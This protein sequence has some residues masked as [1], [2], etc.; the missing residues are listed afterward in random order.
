VLLA[1]PVTINV[2]ELLLVRDSRDP[3]TIIPD[4]PRIRVELYTIQSGDS[5][6]AIAER[7]GLQPETIA[8]SNDRSLIWKL[9]PG[10]VLNIMPV[11][12]VYHQAVGNTTVRDLAIQYGVSDPAVILQSEY[13]NL[14]AFD[15]D[16]VLPSGLWVV[17]PGGRAEAINFAPV[18]ETVSGGGESGGGL[19]SYDPSSPGTC[20]ALAAGIA[21]GWVSP[22]ASYTFMRGFTSFHTG[23][24]L[25]AGVGTPVYA[26][27]SGRVIFAGRSNYGYGIAVVISHGPFSTL[28]GHLNSENVSCGQLVG[29]GQLIGAVGL[30]GNTSGPHLHFEIMYNGI[31]TNPTDI[32]PF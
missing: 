29:A 12:G 32:M 16:T 7:F 4:R 18:V 8:W 10:A 3:Y 5:I 1:Q 28:Y 6:N 11:D 24:D 19:V 20:G 9:T 22:M 21:S 2:S 23:V 13:N 26:A 25:A 27:N 15:A 30:T 14:Q 31:P 17:I